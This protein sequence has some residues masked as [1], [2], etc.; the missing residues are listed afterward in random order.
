MK[1]N[2]KNSMNIQSLLNIQPC[3]GF[4][5]QAKSREEKQT[6]NQNER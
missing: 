5:R 2:V 1:I 3:F 6:K 4:H